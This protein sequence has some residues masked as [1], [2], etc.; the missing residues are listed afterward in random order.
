MLTF[1]VDDVDGDIGTETKRIGKVEAYDADS[2]PFNNIY[3]YLLPICKSQRL[4]TFDLTLTTSGNPDTAHYDI[5]LLT[6]E[7]YQ[8]KSNDA[9]HKASRIICALAR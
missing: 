1:I 5:D 9:S 3:Y 2:P 8:L 7:I 6:G 4:N